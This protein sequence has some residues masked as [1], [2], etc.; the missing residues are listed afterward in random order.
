MIIIPYMLGYYLM[1]CTTLSF[2]K[3]YQSKP[4]DLKIENSSYLFSNEQ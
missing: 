2:E 1:Q 4:F 3:E